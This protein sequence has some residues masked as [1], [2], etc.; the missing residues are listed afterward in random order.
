MKPLKLV[1]SAFGP[2][3]DRTEIDFTK[4]GENTYSVLCSA[5]VEDFFEFFGLE[6]EE[7][8]EATTVNGWLIELI[9]CI[10]QEG[11]SFE[12]KNL[13][14]TVTKADHLMAHEIAVELKPDAEETVEI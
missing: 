11:A 13:S 4:L 9:G 2:Y 1:M 7:D 3:A 14:I 6:P 8:T 12:Y 5:F 10:P